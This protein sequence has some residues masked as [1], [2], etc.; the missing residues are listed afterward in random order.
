MQNKP[1]AA[2]SNNPLASKRDV[3]LRGL[4]SEV[5]SEVAKLMK[6]PSAPPRILSLRVKGDTLRMFTEIEAIL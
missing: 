3:F 1:I 4:S 6:I 5:A 2:I